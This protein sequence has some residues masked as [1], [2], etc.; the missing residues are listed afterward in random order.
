[1]LGACWKKKKEKRKWSK[2]NGN[3]KDQKVVIHT[4]LETR[5]FVL[6]LR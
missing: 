1:M 5:N 2:E 4:L 6:T 3:Q